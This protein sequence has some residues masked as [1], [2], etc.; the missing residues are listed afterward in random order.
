MSV[1]CLPW[2]E[3]PETEAAHDALWSVLA[4]RLRKCG[5]PNVPE[6]LTRGAPVV[7]MLINPRLLMGQCCGYDL[8][9]GFASC[10]QLV[11]TPRYHATGCDGAT[12]R[13][14]VLVR[15]DCEA[16]SLE[17][18]R[19]SVCAVNGFNSHSGANALRALVAP[20]SRKGRFFSRVRI[21][22]AHIN[23]LAF[24]RAREADVMAM[25]CVLHAL[26]ARHRPQGL[27][28]TRVLC[29]SEPAPA[30]PIITRASAD[31]KLIDK[32]RDALGEALSDDSS[33]DAR[34]AMLLDGVT[35]LPLQDYA[36]IIETE[37]VSLRFGYREMHARSPA[38]AR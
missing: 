9:Y 12:Y 22:G 16:R 27:K 11:A 18:L 37:S 10:V 3:L 31:R 8:I 38:L 6:R 23:S 1:A 29:L 2:Y 15:D 14:L 26:L 7:S 13:S 34:E 35:L 25:D 17:G 19:G 28:G 4:R 24:L 36:K 5:V 21:S 33:R 20:L 30:P 32:L